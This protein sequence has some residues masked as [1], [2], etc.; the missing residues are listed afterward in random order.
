MPL[1]IYHNLPDVFNYRSCN[2]KVQKSKGGTSRV[3]NFQEL[4][5]ANRWVGLGGTGGAWEIRPGELMLGA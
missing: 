1:L 4:G 3:V 2:F 5:L